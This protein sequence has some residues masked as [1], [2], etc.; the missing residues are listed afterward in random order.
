MQG[1]TTVASMIAALSWTTAPD[2]IRT[3]VTKIFPYNMTTTAA[4]ASSTTTSVLCVQM[5]I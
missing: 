1:L 2:F 3:S 4:M 5:R